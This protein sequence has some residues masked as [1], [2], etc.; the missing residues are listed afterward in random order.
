M[1]GRKGEF[2]TTANGNKISIT[3]AIFGQHLEIFDY[4]SSLQL[5]QRT[6]GEIDVLI[7][8]RMNNITRNVLLQTQRSLESLNKNQLKVTLYSLEQPIKTA[9]GKSKILLNQFPN[10]LVISNL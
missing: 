8:P 2:I 1:N 4:I 3:A 10:D 5:F 7:V 6:P 9:T